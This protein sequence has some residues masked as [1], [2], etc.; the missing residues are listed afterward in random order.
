MQ[1]LLSRAIGHNQHLL[2]LL[3]ILFQST[4][5]SGEQRMQHQKEFTEWQLGR[6]VKGAKGIR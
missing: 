3:I 6:F 1:Q 2:M 5:Y 4:M